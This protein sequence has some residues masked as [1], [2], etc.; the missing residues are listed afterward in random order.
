MARRSVTSFVS[1]DVG[2]PPSGAAIADLTA[3]LNLR[4]H[5]LRRRIDRTF[6][7]RTLRW[8]RFSL[9]QI[10]FRNRE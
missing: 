2:L 6:A 7:V 5:T 3:R 9:P 4:S 10:L 8:T 1:R